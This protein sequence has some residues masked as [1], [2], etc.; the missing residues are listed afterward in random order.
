MSNYDDIINL[1]HPEPKTFKRM[2]KKDRAAQFGAF[3]ALTGYE[4]E[5]SETARLTDRK[6][7][8]DEY[9]LDS[10]NMKLT[11]IVNESEKKEIEITYFSPDYKKTGGKYLFAKGKVK[12]IDFYE[13]IIVLED[14]TEIPFD[15]VLDIN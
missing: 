4:E 12:K 15:A 2:S 8:L 1:A 14:K 10:L 7:I 13:R 6:I 5:V 9:E 11:E 3:R